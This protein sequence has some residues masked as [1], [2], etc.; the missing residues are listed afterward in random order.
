MSLRVLAVSTACDEY[1]AHPV[2]RCPGWPARSADRRAA[3]PEATRASAVNQLSAIHT[4]GCDRDIDGGSRG[5]TP[6]PILQ[7][8][9][10]AQQYKGRDTVLRNAQIDLY[11]GELVCVVGENGRGKS[12]LLKM[13]TLDET[14][15]HGEISIGN[16]SVWNE[17]ARWRTDMRAR[18]ISFIHPPQDSFG[19]MPW[20]PERNIM[21]WLIRLDGANYGTAKRRARAA[22][23]RVNRPADVLPPK[24]WSEPIDIGRKN[25][26][27]GQLARIAI[28]GAIALQRPIAWR[29]SRWRRWIRT[30]ASRFSGSFEK[31]P[32]WSKRGGCGARGGPASAR[33][34]F[35]S[36]SSGRSCSR[37]AHAL[38][39]GAWSAE[40]SVESHHGTDRSRQRPFEPRELLVGG[41][42]GSS[43]LRRPFMSLAFVFSVAFGAAI[44]LVISAT[45]R[46]TEATVKDL[47]DSRAARAGSRS[48][49]WTVCCEMR[50]PS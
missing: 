30:R 10:L 35:R 16:V 33:T 29:I 26:S 8:F 31:W 11:P 36:H 18:G 7:G 41:R 22:L 17:S 9:E 40:R 3:D 24:R 39:A 44:A 1:R 28:A 32:I 4:R 25:F 13:L 42:G 15:K 14:P 6:Q 50:A 48:P 2:F 19:L 12:T 43:A 38:T 21:H 27:G 34:V 23:T 45:G 37:A 20:S 46:G 47:L 5:S 49:M